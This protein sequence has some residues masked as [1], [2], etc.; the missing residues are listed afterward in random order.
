MV[1][2]P[3]PVSCMS[4][5]TLLE[6]ILHRTQNNLFIYN[7][8]SHIL[9]DSSSSEEEFAFVA[10]ASLADSALKIEDFREGLK[11]MRGNAWEDS[12]I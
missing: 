9:S 6:L 1:P 11:Q 10:N 12:T 3:Y 5:H 8:P 7:H 2:L 4:L